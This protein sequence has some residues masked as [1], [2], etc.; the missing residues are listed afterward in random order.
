MKTFSQIKKNLKQDFSSLKT[1]KVAV[2]GD[3]ATQFL[4][5]ALRG[6][7]YDYGLNLEIWEADFNQIERQVFDTGSELYEFKPEVVIVFHATHKLLGK[8]NK[9]QPEEQSGLAAERLQLIDNIHSAITENLKAKIIYYNY[10]E[11]ND[12]VFGNY[13]NNI[14]S[15]FL[16]QLRKLN[17]ELMQFAAQHTGFYVADISSVQNRL[18]KNNFFHTSVY[19]NTDMVLSIDAIPEVAIT[20]L[21]LIGAMYGKLKKCLILDLDNTTWGG[22]SFISKRGACCTIV[23]LLPKRAKA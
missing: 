7:G 5:Q 4:M 17:Y 8:Y 3:T 10:N 11:I 19:I 2:L 12:S 18:G 20:T 14:E 6:A 16:F 15:S 1:I 22:T 13:A 9:L 21:D 23:T